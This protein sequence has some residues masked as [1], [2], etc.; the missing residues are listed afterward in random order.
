MTVQP[1]SR[2]TLP[3]GILFI[4]ALFVTPCFSALGQL[5]HAEPEWYLPT[6][7]GCR[8]FVQEF[9]QGP[10]TL[11][12]LHGG[13][14]A[15]HSYLLDAFKGL[16]DNYHL[17]FHD[18][19]GSLLSPCPPDKISV[20]KHVED[21]ELLRRALGL[22]HM[23]LVAHSM[24]TFLAMTYEQQHPDHVKGLVLIGSFLARTPRTDLEGQLLH[25]QQNGMQKM[26]ADNSATQLELHQLGMDSKDEK[27]WTPKQQS[28]A[29]H[30]EFARANI[31]HLDRWRQVRGGKAFY[32]TEA[33]QATARTMPGKW[34]FTPSLSARTCPT[35]VIDGDHDY[36]I[37]PA[38]KLFH[39]ATSVIPGVRIAILKDAGHNSWID[40]PEDFHTALQTAL[41][42]TVSCTANAKE[43]R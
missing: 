14:G 11:V 43:E 6:A 1:T 26:L 27:N 17:V 41:Q 3:R 10:E 31:Y 15:E 28:L 8:L 22:E 37:D 2:K 16:D 35:W 36:V 5:A 24:G 4:V 20:Q 30:I 29:W 32:S 19:R 39:T 18:Q 38:G 25:D 40:A 42:S 33:A 21:L 23:N 13:W 9:G 12:V 7:D 34:D